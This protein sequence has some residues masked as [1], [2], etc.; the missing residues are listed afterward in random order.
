MFWNFHEILLG[1]HFSPTIPSGGK[2]GSYWKPLS[3]TCCHS[4]A[5]LMLCPDNQHVVDNSEKQG[6]GEANHSPETA[7]G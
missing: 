2:R 5:K 1:G 3:V 7:S 4:T 6:L